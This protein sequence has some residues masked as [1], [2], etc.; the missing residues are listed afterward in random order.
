[1]NAYLDIFG[2]VLRL[3]TFQVRERPLRQAFP[4]VDCAV[5]DRARRFHSAS[6]VATA[7]RSGR[8][9]SSAPTA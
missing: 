7:S 5:P 1:M 8:T 3:V 6:A 9:L 2:D 4:E